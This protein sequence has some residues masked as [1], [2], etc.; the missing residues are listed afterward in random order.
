MCPTTPT[1]ITGRR[2]RTATNPEGP[3]RLCGRAT[4]GDWAGLMPGEVPGL[5]AGAI[6]SASR[7]FHGRVAHFAV[8]D[9]AMTASQVADLNA[10]YRAMYDPSLRAYPPRLFPHDRDDQVT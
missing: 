1:P 4:P 8:W 9:M 7:F 10:K 2:T 3:I 5:A 6:W